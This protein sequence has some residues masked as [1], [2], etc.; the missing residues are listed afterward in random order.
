M[1]ALPGIGNGLSD[2]FD[3]ALPVWV[4]TASEQPG[5]A[6]PTLPPL[7]RCGDHAGRGATRKGDLDLFPI[8]HASHEFGCLPAELSQADGT[9]ADDIAQVLHRPRR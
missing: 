5:D 1:R 7:R 6:V 9:H 2:Q 8:L 4:R 3:V